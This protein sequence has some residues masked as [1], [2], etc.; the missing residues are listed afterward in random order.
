MNSHAKRIQNNER[1]AKKGLSRQALR[2]AQT[3][4]INC[5]LEAKKAHKP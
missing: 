5:E 2:A 4:R 1:L 3:R